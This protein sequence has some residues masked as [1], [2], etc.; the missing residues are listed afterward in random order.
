VGKGYIL[1]IGDL[2]GII[3]VIGY[4]AAF[5]DYPIGN[6]MLFGE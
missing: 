1:L 3:P 2:K 5:V 4:A 6:S